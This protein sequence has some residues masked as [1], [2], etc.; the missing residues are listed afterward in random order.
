MI[1]FGGDLV[2]FL[3]DSCSTIRS[4]M[5]H[6]CFCRVCSIGK[7]C[8]SDLKWWNSFLKCELWLSPTST[9]FFLYV[10]S[11]WKTPLKTKIPHSD[12]CA[13]HNAIKIFDEPPTT[14]LVIFIYTVLK[15]FLHLCARHY[16]KNINKKSTWRREI[17]FVECIYLTL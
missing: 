9:S 12:F 10:R 6:A 15:Y 17:F 16:S 2:C 14:Q 13:H 1:F 7:S 5:K 8:E 3:F 11:V 4:D